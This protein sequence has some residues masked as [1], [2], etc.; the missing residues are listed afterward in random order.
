M[1]IANADLWIISPFFLSCENWFRTNLVVAIPNK[2]F[3]YSFVYS[4][5]NPFRVDGQCHSLVETDVIHICLTYVNSVIIC[6]GD[7]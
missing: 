6:H 3:V 4:P 1:Y 2:Y 5:A 7:N